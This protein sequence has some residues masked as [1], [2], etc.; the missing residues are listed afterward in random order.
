MKHRHLPEGWHWAKLHEFL[1]QRNSWITIEEDKIYRRCTV[2][3][4]NTGVIP[5]DTIIGSRIHT[6]RQQ[7]TQE[8]DFIVAEIDAKE[9]SFGIVKSDTAGSIVSGHYFLF[10]VNEL[11]DRNFFE[12]CIGHGLLQNQVSAVG[13]TNYSAI[14]ADDLLHYRIPYPPIDEQR[15]IAEVL[16][17]ADAN[18]IRVEAQIETAQ[19]VKRGVMQRL[20][21]Y[22]LAG[23]GAPTKETDAGEIPKHWLIE[24]LKNHTESSAFGPRFP[25]NAYSDTG[26]VATLRTTD[27]DDSG[28]I[29]Y[30]TMPRAKLNLD[31]FESHILKKGD[32]TITRS[33]TIG[34][35]SVFEGY[36]L[37]VLPGAFLIRFRLY[38]SIAPNFLRQYLNSN[39]GRRR[40]LDIAAGGVQKN[41]Q[42]S[43]MLLLKIPVPPIQEQLEIAA[44]LEAHD[45]IVRNLQAEAASLRV[46][47]HGLMQKLLSGEARV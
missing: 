36:N 31:N 30:E 2:S 41:L 39:L 22:G 35:V 46:V 47:K 28:E 7:L 42:G 10:T 25:A 11:L 15:R 26:N 32:L 34:V 13:S 6:K 17:D 21:T 4:Y 33:G 23:E 16:R 24:P 18:I 40:V 14:R 5:R 19:E 43:A 20:F 27:L 29:N 12:Q 45:D 9:G 38:S 1:T 44:I 3:W 37:P 8:G